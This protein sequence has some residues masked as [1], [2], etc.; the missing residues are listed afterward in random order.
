MGEM[1]RTVIVHAYDD[2]DEQH[3]GGFG[4][5]GYGVRQDEI[6]CKKD[7]P[8]Y[9]M[10]TSDAHTIVFEL[11]NRSSKTLRFPP[12]PDDAMWVAADDQN[13][14]GNACH[15]KQ[16]VFGTGVSSDGEQLT[17]KNHNKDKKRF[18]FVLNFQET[19]KDGTT[20]RVPYDPI[21]ANQNGGD[22]S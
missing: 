22:Q 2:D 18:K 1:K 21:W 12:N 20:Q 6:H 13:C 16:V 11:A 3:G 15:Q 14:P 9:R 7:N 19:K 4:M 17:V 10:K 8:R 5:S